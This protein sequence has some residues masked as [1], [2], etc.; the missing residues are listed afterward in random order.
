MLFMH[1]IETTDMQDKYIF[2]MTYFCQTEDKTYFIA[3]F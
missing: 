1:Y 3:T 2:Q